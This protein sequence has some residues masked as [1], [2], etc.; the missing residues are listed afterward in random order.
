MHQALCWLARLQNVWHGAGEP[1]ALNEKVDVLRG[2]VPKDSRVPCIGRVS[3]MVANFRSLVPREKSL[4]KKGKLLEHPRQA[5]DHVNCRR[6]CLCA[7]RRPDASEIL[8][9]PF[10]NANGVTVRLIF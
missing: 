10:C 7:V 9:D 2:D 6:H 4:M 3:H 5:D 1:F 8:G